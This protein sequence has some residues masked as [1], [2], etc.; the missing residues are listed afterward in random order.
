LITCS[1]KLLWQRKKLISLRVEIRQLS[2]CDFFLFGIADSYPSFLLQI[3][4]W[5]LHI[6]YQDKDMFLLDLFY[7]ITWQAKKWCLKNISICYNCYVSLVKYSYPF[8][9]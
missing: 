4:N 2:M 3:D 9:M 8:Y 5:F 1:I 7:H 6:P